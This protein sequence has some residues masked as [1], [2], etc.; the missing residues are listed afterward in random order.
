MS[1]S[2]LA[3][4]AP[5][6]IAVLRADEISHP[7]RML[8]RGEIVRLFPG[9]F[10]FAADWVT[11]PPWDRYLVR[12]HAAAR[13]HPEGIIA[14]E[15]AS[16]LSGMPVFGDPRT[17]HMLVSGSGNSRTVNGIRFHTSVNDR[18]L[19]AAGGI[20]LTSPADTAVDLARHR[21]NA[22]GRAAADA[23][24]R[25]DHSLRPEHLSAM[26]ESR[27]SKRGRA[28]ARWP[29]AGASGVRE[30]PLESIASAVFEWL[31]FAAPEQQVR[32]RSPDGTVDRCDFVWP[33]ERVAGE[34]DGDLKYDGRF[35]TPGEV[36]RRQN[37]RDGRLRRWMNRIVHFGWDETI[38]VAPL[39]GILLGAGL[40]PTERE[41][42]A[43]LFTLRRAL[44]A[45]VDRES[46][47][48]ARDKGADPGLGAQMSSHR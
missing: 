6:P 30:S 25:V 18:R 2:A 36:M 20:L 27:S 40:R 22:I 4:V 44:S 26:N 17:V 41:Q 42:T 47:P 1:S 5:A 23:A 32:Y 46:S 7:E 8:A 35:G 38:A 10:V 14:L 48:A 37:A 19:I 3:S 34:A 45:A 33:E 16:A 15:S 24:L 13:V 9:L 39:R 11:L 21:H 31:G 43:P 12:V 29:L 28:L